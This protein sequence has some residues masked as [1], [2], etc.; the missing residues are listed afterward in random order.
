MLYADYPG[1][2]PSVLLRVN[3]AAR[4]GTGSKKARLFEPTTKLDQEPDHRLG[5][6]KQPKDANGK[7]Q[8]TPDG[9]ADPKREQL[10]VGPLLLPRD[11]VKTKERLDT[12]HQP[13]PGYKPYIGG[14]PREELEDSS[15]N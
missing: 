5:Y 13:H 10:F 6:T 4:P 8:N 3:L 14:P 2:Q 12:P 11:Q 15:K 9:R 7:S 1:N